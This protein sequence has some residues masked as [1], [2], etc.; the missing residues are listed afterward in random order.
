MN[1]ILNIILLTL[2]STV[3]SCT[4]KENAFEEK[5]Q[6]ISFNDNWKFH[7]GDFPDAKTTDF[8]DSDWRTLNLP[9]DWSIEGDFSKDHPAGT[10]GGALPGGIGWYRKTFEYDLAQNSKLFI[11]FDG[12]YM[13]S[14]VF[15]NGTS[16]GN[17]PNGYVSFRYDLTPY[18]N[19]NQKNVLAVRVNND[20]QPN[21]RWYSG[22][23]I[24]RNVRLN[25]TSDIYVDLWGTYITTPEISKEKSLFSI[26]T[27]VN[28]ESNGEKEIE[29]TSILLNQDNK[30]ISRSSTYETLAEN[31]KES[32][33]HFISLNDPQLWSVD[34]PYLYKIRTEIR[35]DGILIDDYVTTTGIRSF[36]FDVKN[37]FFLNGQ[38]L[39]I[40]GVCMH[41][42]LGCLGVAINERAI[43]R[44]LE[45]LKEMGCNGIRTAHN[46]PSPEL[47]NLCDKMGFIVMNETFDMWEKKKTKY[48]YS[49][50]FKDWHEKDLNDIVTRDRNH[51]SIFMWC[52]GN[53]VLEQWSD[54]NADALTLEEANLVLNFGHQNNQIS[55]PKENLSSNELLCRKLVD[56]IKN[57]D[58]TRP[59]TDGCNE[60]DPENH[61]FKSGALDIIGFNYHDD[62]FSTVPEK[63]AGKPFIISESVSALMTRGYY[64]MQSDKKLLCPERWDKSF[65]N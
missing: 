19:H 38:H 58:S 36:D 11:D 61:L 65:F 8:N 44:Q 29:L 26:I 3:C 40:N 43:E 37:G 49:R 5:R 18:L 28:N 9:H 64:Q 6:I 42:D 21:S 47:L 15:L 54:A 16:L 34:N 20:E 57:L 10:G 50:F 60:P 14:E 51:P 56:M 41:Q 32:F 17:R 53:E 59:V 48:D 4:Q 13:D 12:V 1:N 27:T 25:E 45:K 30:E 63:F 35:K 55:S 23:G 24:Y 46:P 33:Q 39:K 7:Q 22:S 31:E 62:Y 2:I 52:V